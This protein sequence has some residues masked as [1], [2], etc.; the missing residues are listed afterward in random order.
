MR[1]AQLPHHRTFAHDYFGYFIHPFAIAQQKT[2]FFAFGDAT[3]TSGLNGR[4]QLDSIK[5]ITA[6]LFHFLQ[7]P[8]HIHHRLHQNNQVPDFHPVTISVCR[9]ASFVTTQVQ[10]YTAV[11]QCQ[12]RYYAG[13]ASICS[14]I[15]SGRSE[16]KPKCSRAERMSIP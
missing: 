6:R 15:I 12:A 1:E 7:Q 3:D 14:K 2:G 9:I 10:S 11:F 4:C 5:R 13:M 16:C 8:I